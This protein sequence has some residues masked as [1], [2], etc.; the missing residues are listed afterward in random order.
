MWPRTGSTE[1]Q[2]KKASLDDVD[3]RRG[4]H[5]IIQYMNLEGADMSRIDQRYNVNDAKNDMAWKKYLQQEQRYFNQNKRANDAYMSRF[6]T[7]AD[8]KTGLFGGGAKAFKSRLGT[9][10]VGLSD[11]PTMAE[12][13]A[14]GI[15]I[16]GA[17]TFHAVTDPD[18]GS[19]VR[20]GSDFGWYDEVSELDQI[21]IDTHGNF[22]KKPYNYVDNERVTLGS[23]GPNH[24]VVESIT[25]EL[26]AD[27][28][29]LVARQPSRLTAP[30]VPPMRLSAS[31]AENSLHVEA[32]PMDRTYK[33]RPSLSVPSRTPLTTGAAPASTPSKSAD[34]V[35]RKHHA[36]KTSSHF[37]A[38]WFFI[39]AACI[40]LFAVVGY[41]LSL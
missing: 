35:R 38:D 41:G 19:F 6:D 24:A 2:Y 10:V 7:V 23:F 34:P 8:L 5:D 3:P 15:G 30:M 14:V 33:F 37:M 4:V 1:R 20:K 32:G 12:D 16:V 27:V 25:N 29:L 21:V 36:K 39:F 22:R 9:E 28:N 18:T 11:V 26:D 31:P 17:N 13:Y 40:V